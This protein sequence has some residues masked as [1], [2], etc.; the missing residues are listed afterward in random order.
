MRVFITAD[1]LV[2][3]KCN[4][5]NIIMIGMQN[6]WYLPTINYMIYEYME[7]DFPAV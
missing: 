2:W 3:I 4:K 7:P 6:I 5:C 1:N